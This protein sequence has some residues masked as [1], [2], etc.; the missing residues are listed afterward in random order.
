MHLKE[1]E[2]VISFN[3]GDVILINMNECYAFDGCFEAA[4]PCTP[5]W[6]SD[7]HKYID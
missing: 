3:K 5:A 2:E 1:K 4:V 7:Q 6:T